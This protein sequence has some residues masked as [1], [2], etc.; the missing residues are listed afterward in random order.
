MQSAVQST[1]ITLTWR[2]SSID[3]VNTYTVSYTRVSGCTAAPPGSVTSTTTTTTITGLQEN[4]GYRFRLTATN[5]AGTSTPD[6]VYE[7][8]MPSTCK[9]DC[10]YYVSNQLFYYSCSTFRSSTPT[11]ATASWSHYFHNYMGT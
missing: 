5:S 8:T 2:S 3:F 4:I 11:N 10:Y 1:Q 6:A 9:N 7:Y